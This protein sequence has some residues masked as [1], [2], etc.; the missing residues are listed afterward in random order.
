MNTIE[1]KNQD[2]KI[3]INELIINKKKSNITERE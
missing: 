1:K 3:I 2:R